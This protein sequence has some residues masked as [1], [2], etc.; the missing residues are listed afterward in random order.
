MLQRH[1]L[2]SLLEGVKVVKDSVGEAG[3]IKPRALARLLCVLNRSSYP[4]QVGQD[5]ISACSSSSAWL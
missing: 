3:E 1:G 4:L 2:Q 5:G